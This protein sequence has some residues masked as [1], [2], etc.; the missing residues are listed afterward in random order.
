MAKNRE[1]SLK[2]AVTGALIAREEEV[3]PLLRRSEKV[4]S[5]REGRW[6]TGEPISANAVS[7]PRGGEHTRMRHCYS[8]HVS[9]ARGTRRS[10]PCSSDQMH[11]WRRAASAPPLRNLEQR[12][13]LSRT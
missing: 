7:H 2:S 11:G 3:G 6:C 1:G 8:P 4:N 9:P 12:A 10:K 13:T 5:H